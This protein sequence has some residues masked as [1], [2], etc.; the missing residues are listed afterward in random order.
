MTGLLEEIKESFDKARITTEADG[1]GPVVV[2]T[3]FPDMPEGFMAM[4]IYYRKVLVSLVRR[5]FRHH[6]GASMPTAADDLLKLTVPTMHPKLLAMLLQCFADGVRIGHRDD[7]RI[8]MA[9]HFEVMDTIYESAAFVTD[10][11]TMALGF[12]EDDGIRAYF[13]EYLENGIAHMHHLTG[14][15]HSEADPNQVWDLWMLIGLATIGSC[16]LA[17]HAMGS[18]WRER[19]VLDGIE[20]ATG[21]DHESE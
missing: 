16:Y 20:I 11:N 15:A 10:S 8:K 6:A 21:D 19:D 7:Q 5:G 12:A 17:G 1:G 9:Y 4:Q 2:G 14:F 18:S 13:T 3:N